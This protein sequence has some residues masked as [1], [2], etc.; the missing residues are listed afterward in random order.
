MKGR[1]TSGW[2]GFKKCKGCK[3]RFLSTSGSRRFCD[4][5]ILEKTV[6]PVCGGEKSLYRKFCGN[7]CASKWKQANL[8]QVRTI[9][10]NRKSPKRA[11]SISIA[12]TG[13]PRLDIR[14]DKNPNWK[15]GTYGTER[16]RI[17]GTVEY[18][19]WRKAVFERDAYT[20]QN[21]HRKGGRLQADHILPYCKFPKEIFNVDNGKTLCFKC[22]KNTETW[23]QNVHKVYLIGNPISTTESPPSA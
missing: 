2:S 5:C 21:C 23:G 16:H 7:S 15:G 22:H 12:R 1:F 13:K 4:R 14:G 18:K 8:P 9:S 3:K 6:C 11:I 17:M 10:Q 20:C 19:N